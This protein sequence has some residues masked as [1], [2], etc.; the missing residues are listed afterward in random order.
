MQ[1]FEDK[2]PE[3]VF[4]WKDSHTTAKGWIVIN[5]LR[6]GA[7]AGGSR[8][9]GGSCGARCSRSGGCWRRGGRGGRGRGDRFG[10]GGRG[11]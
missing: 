4:E 2:K 1:E 11:G 8:C 10:A 6:G 9:G 5:S 3:I 7:A